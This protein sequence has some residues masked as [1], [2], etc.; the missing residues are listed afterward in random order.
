V[1]L[2]AELAA[3]AH[4]CLAVLDGRDLHGEVARTGE[5]LATVVG[6]DLEE[7]DNGRFRIARKVAK[8]RVISTIDTDAR[9][10]HKAAAWLRW[11]QGP[12]RRRPDSEIVT[13]TIVTGQHRRRLR[14]RD[15]H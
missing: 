7:G 10:G 13:D 3:D 12:H 9:H 4:A 2:V 1:D 6:Q 14:C 11:L 8:D 15:P 5:L